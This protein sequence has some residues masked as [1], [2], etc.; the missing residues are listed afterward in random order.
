LALCLSVRLASATPSAQAHSG[1]RLSAQAHS[2]GWLFS[3]QSDEVDFSKPEFYAAPAARSAVAMLGSIGYFYEPVM[4][5][6]FTLKAYTG[7][8][9]G[10]CNLTF[11]NGISDASRVKK[12][13]IRI[14][15][16]VG[17]SFPGIVYINESDPGS[18]VMPYFRLHPVDADGGVADDRFFSISDRW[19]PQQSEWTDIELGPAEIQKLTDSSGGIKTL[20]WS[21]C[22]NST[23]PGYGGVAYF[24]IEGISYELFETEAY[25]NVT[26]KD[27]DIVLASQSTP[28]FVSELQGVSKTGHTLT[29]L[30]DGQ[31]FDFDTQIT[32]DTVLSADFSVNSYTLKFD[33]NGGSAVASM[34][35]EYGTAAVMPIDP[36]RDGWYFAG[37]YADKLFDERFVFDKVTAENKTLYAKW[38]LYDPES[39][40]SGAPASD[41][42]N[43]SP[44]Y[45]GLGI[46]LAVVA[47]I[48]AAVGI[49]IMKRNKA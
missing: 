8:W 46:A 40:R 36:T 34:T 6:K 1:D 41:G 9:Y 16:D 18:I 30:K 31:I 45:I 10:A 43:W 39:G 3:G 5:G 33:S 20:Q 26:F 23:L 15:A 37:W 19:I 2:G 14:K 4:D 12:L 29:W 22:H 38:T 11:K 7:N 21:S 32:E 48:A 49:F 44:L 25:H 28:W 24:V 13:T 27:G 42:K 35:A 17:A 47:G